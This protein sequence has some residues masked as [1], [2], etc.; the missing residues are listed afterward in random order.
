MLKLVERFPHFFNCGG[1]LQDLE[2]KDGQPYVTHSLSSSILG[3][4][5]SWLAGQSYV[6]GSLAATRRL[7][8]C[9][10]AWI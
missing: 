10:T 2:K 4:H 5:C 6:Q 3:L 7:P 8:G 9:L 1:F